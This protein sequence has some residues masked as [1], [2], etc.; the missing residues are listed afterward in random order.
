M[1]PDILL[2]GE[3]LVERGIAQ[4]CV[5]KRGESLREKRGRI[6]TRTNHKPCENEKGE[7]PAQM[8]MG[9]E[10][11][12]FIAPHKGGRSKN[13]KADQHKRRD[14]FLV[15]RGYSHSFMLGGNAT[16]GRV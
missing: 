16:G 7:M 1:R 9:G 4:S 3:S 10:L 5:N 14:T 15:I 12:K 13:P 8:C 11:T 2:L 6:K